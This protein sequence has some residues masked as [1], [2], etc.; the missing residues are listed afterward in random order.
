M[1]NLLLVPRRGRG[2]GD[3]RGGWAWRKGKGRTEG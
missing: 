2:H 1:E 3:P